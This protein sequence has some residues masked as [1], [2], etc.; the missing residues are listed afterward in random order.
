[1]SSSASAG[2]ER[3]ASHR[4]SRCFRPDREVADRQSANGGPQ[5]LAKGSKIDK[6][7]LASVEKFHWFDIRPADDEVAHN[8]KAS[9][10]RWSKRATAST[11]LSKKSARSSRK[12]MS[13]PRAC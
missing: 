5:K 11:W 12:V 4:G 13:C 2:P 1:M 3:P 8:W 6:A 7:Y 9:R 10:T